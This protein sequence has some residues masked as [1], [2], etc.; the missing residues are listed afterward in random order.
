MEI[1]II[2]CWCIWIIRNHTIFR[3]IPTRCLRGLDLF[4]LIF[5]ELLWRAKKYFLAIESWLEHAV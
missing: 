2:M 4:K 5:R 1:I 3:G